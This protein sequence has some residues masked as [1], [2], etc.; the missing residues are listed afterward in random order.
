MEVPELRYAR[1]GDLHIAYQRWGNGPDVIVIPGLAG[2]VELSWEEAV[3]RRAR[4]Y[5]AKYVKLIEFDKRGIG[6]SDRFDRAPTLEERVGDINAVMDAEGISRSHI[7]GM[8]EGGLMAQFFA[9]MHPERVDRL[10][11]INSM[12]GISALSESREEAGDPPIEEMLPNVTRMIEGWGREPELFVEL[13]DPSK[14]GD[15]AFIRW[16]GRF[17]RQTCSRSDIKRQLDSVLMLD[18]NDLLERIR[19]PT[20]VMH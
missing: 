11:L 13:F 17:Q 1:S 19:A 14:I 16:T 8:S 5:G 4:E 18:A 2:N 12:A 15:P 9:A 3:Y 20:L 6:S 7:V 10:C